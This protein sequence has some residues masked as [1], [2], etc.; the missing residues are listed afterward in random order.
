MTLKVLSRNIKVSILSAI[1][2]AFAAQKH[3]KVAPKGQSW[4]L[5]TYSSGL[6][7]FTPTV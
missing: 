5:L 7:T 1:S 4:L 6:L 2:E 3:H